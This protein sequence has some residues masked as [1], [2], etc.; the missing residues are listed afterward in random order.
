MNHDK[1]G[2]EIFLPIQVKAQLHKINLVHP[3]VREIYMNS[4]K[5]LLS[6]PL[7]SIRNSGYLLDLFNDLIDITKEVFE[8]NKDFT[9]SFRNQIL[10][11][12]AFVNHIQKTK[13]KLVTIIYSQKVKYLRRYTKLLMIET[14][15]V[16]SQILM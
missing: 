8:T 12:Y 15:H 2:K 7:V 10:A 1:N 3:Q 14:I 16:L 6:E 11:L 4:L 13:K 9:A 5:A